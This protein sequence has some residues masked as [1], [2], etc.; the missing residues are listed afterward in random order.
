MTDRSDFKILTQNIFADL[1]QYR[2]LDERLELIAHGIA[3]ELPDVVAV[4][5]LVRA[6][7]CGDLGTRLVSAIN[8]ICGETLYRLDYARADGSGESEYA[9]ETGLALLSRTQRA[10]RAEIRKYGAQVRLTTTLGGI[11]Y[12][13]PDDRVALRTSQR[14]NGRVVLDTYVTHL[15]DQNETSRTGVSIRLQQTHEL[16]RFVGEASNP[17]S[18]VILAGDLNDVPDS[19]TIGYLIEAGFVDVCAVAGSPPGF[20]ND[21]DDIRLDSDE[22]SHN[23][24][25]DYIFFRPGRGCGYQ[26]V[27]ARPF[28]DRPRRDQ[29]GGWLW[30][31]DHIGVSATIRFTNGI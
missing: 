6:G 23:Q 20:T 28:L 18:S 3:A 9:F 26:I 16:I 1:P 17:E 19:E 22:A 29:N 10:G 21:R 13:L 27:D 2:R 24:R 8:Q 11:N 30:A 12:R 5:E 4:Q 7:A 14:L 25:I 15:T 31:S